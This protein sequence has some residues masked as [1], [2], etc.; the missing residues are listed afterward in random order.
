M[1][2]RFSVVL[3]ALFCQLCYSQQ[4]QVRVYDEEQANGQLFI[5]ADN[6]E[7]HLVSVDLTLDL[8]GIKTEHQDSDHL[9]LKPNTKAQI[10]AILTPIPGKSWNYRSS[11]KTHFGDVNIIRYDTNFVYQLPFASGT[12]EFVS[13]GYFG[14]LSHGKEYAL[15]FDL[16]QNTPVHAARGGKVVKVVDIHDRGCPNASCTKYNNYILIE[17]SDGSYADYAHLKKNGAVVKPG[18]EVRQGDLIGYSGDTGWATGPHLHFA[19]FIPTVNNR[20]TVAT[21]FRTDDGKEN[22]VEEGRSYVRP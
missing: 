22:Q 4:M 10:L 12:K 1:T 17:H 6:D 11:F 18:A 21:K 16:D 7:Y 2:K 8:K 19:V 5:M 15:D 3:I 13:Q 9:V 20:K 14:R